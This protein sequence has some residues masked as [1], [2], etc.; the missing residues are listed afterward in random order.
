MLAGVALQPEEP[1]MLPYSGVSSRRSY[2]RN[3]PA[4]EVWDLGPSRRVRGSERSYTYGDQTRR[5]EVER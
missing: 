2:I 4:F 5:G 1:V 3:R